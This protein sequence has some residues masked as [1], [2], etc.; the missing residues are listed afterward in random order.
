MDFKSKGQALAT[1][2]H[3]LHILDETGLPL[4]AIEDDG[5]LSLTT[6]ETDRPVIFEIV[7]PF[8]AQFKRRKA[9]LYNSAQ[10]NK[11]LKHSEAERE[12]YATVAAGVAG[13]QNVIWDGAEME[14]S[15]DNAQKLI[16]AFPPAGE[17]V[18][19]AMA[20]R[21]NFTGSV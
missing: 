15:P 5:R 2:T 1:T 9:E 19:E 13:W 3:Q 6:D 21:G 14:F 18:L 12:N 10:T 7:S 8:S 11:R 4:Y 20:D 17:Q 16:A